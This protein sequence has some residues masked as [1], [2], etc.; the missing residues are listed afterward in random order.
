MT[1]TIPTWQQK[2]QAKQAAAAAK[3]PAEWRLPAHLLATADP[4]SPE[5]V[6]SVPRDCGLLTERELAITETVDA[7][8]LLAQIA[9]GKYSAVEVT[10]AFCKRAAIAQQLTN[11]LTETFF[12][13]AL[14]RAQELDTHLATTGQPVGP[15]HGLPI[16]LKDM[17][18]V[19]GVASTLGYVSFLDRPPATANSPLV[20]VLL[21]AGAVVYVKTN[22]PQTL[23]TADSHN[24]VFGRVL[25]PHRR[26]LTAGGSSGGES[27]LIALRGSLLG[28]ASDIAGSIRIPA[29]CCGLVGFKPSMGRVPYS[30]ILN[31]GKPGYLSGISAVAGPICHSIRDATLFLQTVCNVRPDDFDDVALGIPWTVPSISDKLRIG[32][33]TADP[34][35]PLHPNIARTLHRAAEKLAA[36]GHEIVDITAQLPLMEEA[37]DTAFGLFG[38]DADRTAISH[39]TA[40][41]EPLVPSLGIVNGDKKPNPAPTLDDLFRLTAR[42]AEITAQTR[43]VFV[44]NKL[45]LILAPAYQ[46]CALVHDRYAHAWYTVFWNLVDSPS[47]VLPFG[48]SDAQ[49]DREWVR[50]DVIYRPPY[51]PKE[52]EGAPCHVQ[53]VGRRL[54]EEVLARQAE[55]VEAVLKDN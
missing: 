4:V 6:L 8:A 49:A 21:A 29:H 19:A 24:N 35:L 52:V 42:K 34:K 18:H 26:T 37:N 53:L 46:S 33:F 28:V 3:I 25:N 41:G 30:G 31:A 12:D 47:C 51:Q 32:L 27:A 20:D 50:Q 16:S 40:A 48:K 2:V 1:S 5:N 17:L 13:Q 9:A 44:E 10:T 43:R 14:I 39:L 38:L 55:L 22:I 36:A 11:C 23:M 45:D 54:R 7:T 15:L